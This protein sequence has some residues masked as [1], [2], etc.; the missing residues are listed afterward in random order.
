[1]QRL[2]GLPQL[3]MKRVGRQ[4]TC[5]PTR[6]CVPRQR[7]MLRTPCLVRRFS[8]ACWLSRQRV[9]AT[10]TFIHTCSVWTAPW[11]RSSRHGLLWCSSTRCCVLRSMR[12]RRVK[13][14]GCRWCTTNGRRPSSCMARTV[15]IEYFP[16]LVPPAIQ[17]IPTRYTCSLMSS[18]WWV[19]GYCTMP[20]M[21]RMAWNCYGMMWTLPWTVQGATQGLPFQRVC[22]TCAQARPMYPFGSTRFVD[23][24]LGHWLSIHPMRP[25]RV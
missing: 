21:M 13:C 3:W 6:R 7:R 5:T 4:M 15:W 8:Q 10:C 19:C 16:R 20:S 12:T 9:R 23:T 14:H 24:H 17:S 1:M 18:A 11:M 22:R 2:R 25:S